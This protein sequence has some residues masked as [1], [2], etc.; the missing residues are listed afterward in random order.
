MT[1]SVRLQRPVASAAHPP[2]PGS[3]R[4]LGWMAAIGI[5]GAIAVMIGASFVRQDWMYPPLRLPAV[6]PP[7]ELR[8]HVSGSL[9]SVALWAAALLA[10]AGLVA[11]LLAARRGAHGP[12][13]LMLIGAA[14]AAIALMMLPPAGSTD[15]LDYAAYGRLAL[16]GHNPYIATPLYVRITDPGFALSIPTRWQQ[17]VSLYGPAAT[18]EQYLA[19]KIG[20]DSIARVV[21]WLKMWNALAFGAV[22]LVL[23]RV[24]RSRP[25]ARLRAHLL[26]TV[27]PLLLWVLVAA[28]H[29]DLLAAAAGLIGLLAIGRLP[30]G[31]QPRLWRA[32]AAGAL[33]GVAADIK[34]DFAL[35]GL[36]LAW[37]LRRS[38]PALLAAVGGA[39][40][41][42][43]PTYAWL[44]KPAVDALFARRDKTSQDSF[45]RFAD[46]TN[47]RYLIVLALLLFVGIAILLLRRMPAGDRLRP[48]IRPALAISVAWLVIR[49]YQLPWYDAMIFCVLALYPATALDWVLLAR[50]GAATIGTMPG[51]PN[52]VPGTALR[53]VDVFLVHGL[54]PAVLVACAIGVVVLAVSGQWGVH[55]EPGARS[56]LSAGATTD[57][58]TLPGRRD[59]G[60]LVRA[61]LSGGR[62]VVGLADV[63][64]V[65]RVQPA[66]GIADLVTGERSPDV[67]ENVAV[68]SGCG[69]Q[70]PVKLVGGRVEVRAVGCA[71][72][73]ARGRSGQVVQLGVIEQ[74][75]ARV[76]RAG[77]DSPEHRVQLGWQLPGHLGLGCLDRADAGAG[78]RQ[79]AR[80]H[81]A[82]EAD[83]ISAYRDRYQ[84]RRGAERG[85]LAADHRRRRRARAGDE[86]EARWCVGGGPQLRVGLRA[87]VA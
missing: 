8:V 57:V 7:F 40:V 5:G 43:V 37:A 32:A 59:E 11:G 9:V 55:A 46:L 79:H 70:L 52:G 31:V 30:P 68:P 75:N 61:R 25:A 48:A 29:V 83:V 13:R 44:G 63:K 18:I 73:D 80:F 86:R 77:R 60:R 3:V 34:I 66:A 28:G 87:A 16:L 23:D 56:A 24:L 36:G 14:L 58:G 50:L 65:N 17:Q 84:R 53:S 35:F 20:G 62:G 19:A 45:Y 51:N 21:F 15:A 10:L 12:I 39:L 2:G 41:I 26:W 22:A 27:N 42:L 6:G 72:P 82:G 85:Q 81:H 69:P 76:G 67:A 47:W 71:Q 33:V 49:P 38:V 4:L 54:V 74:D 78:R 64:D 1:D